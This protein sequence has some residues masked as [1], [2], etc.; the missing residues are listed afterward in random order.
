MFD[1]QGDDAV[2]AQKRSRPLARGAAKM[3][4][5]RIVDPV[6]SAA[7]AMQCLPPAGGLEATKLAPTS[8]SHQDQRY[9]AHRCLPVFVIGQGCSALDT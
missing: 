3:P 5:S 2:A 9:G 6:K 1:L 7:F 4:L 8:F